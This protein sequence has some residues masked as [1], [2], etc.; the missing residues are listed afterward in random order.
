M[1]D[2]VPMS[3][4]EDGSFNRENLEFISDFEIRISDLK[5]PAKSGIFSCVH[6]SGRFLGYKQVLLSQ[7]IDV[8]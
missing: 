7:F 5:N 1:D 8:A 6:E 3:R 4:P 2:L